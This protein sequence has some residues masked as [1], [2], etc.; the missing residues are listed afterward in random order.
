MKKQI[1]IVGAVV[2]ATFLLSGCEEWNDTS[3]VHGC[4]DSIAKEVEPGVMP[5]IHYTNIFA[6]NPNYTSVRLYCTTY[7]IPCG[8]S[9]TGY[10]EFQIEA[11][12]VPSGEW[13][14]TT[15][16]A[17]YNLRNTQDKVVISARVLTDRISGTGTI[18]TEIQSSNEI[19]LTYEELKKWD[20]EAFTVNTY[21]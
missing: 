20:G 18:V 1:V 13:S 2:F 4:D 9:A 21:L 3:N 14:P 19:T 11:G 17:F 10:N 7:K 8:S 12:D 15:A 6:G 16:G 5:V